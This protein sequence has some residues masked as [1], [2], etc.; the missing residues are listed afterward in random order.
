MNCYSYRDVEDFINSLINDGYD[1]YC[2]EEGVLGIGNWIC[3]S[4]DPKKWNFETK[5]VYLNEW[6]SGQTLRKF[7]KLSKRQEALLESVI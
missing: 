2:I 3:L 1:C 7:K 4:N 5:E 6:S